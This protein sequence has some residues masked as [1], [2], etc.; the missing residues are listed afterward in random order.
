M[1]RSA[2]LN[3]VTDISSITH[4]A[5][6]SGTTPPLEQGDRLTRHEFELRYEA[7]PE[8]KKAE[9]IEGIVYMG[10]PVKYKHGR[11]HRQ[12]NHWLSAYCVETPGTD[13]A[14]NV[15]NRLDEDNDPQP[16]L[17]LRIEE[18]YGGQSRVD[19]DGYLS[20]APELIAEIASSS[21][22][23]DLHD[24]LNVYRRHGV[25]EYVV[26]R[27]R[28]KQLDWFCLEQGHYVRQTPDAKGMIASNIFPGL[29]L[30]VGALLAGEMAAVLNELHKGLA[31]AAHK[32]FVRRLAAQKR[33]LKKQSGSVT[34]KTQ[35][36][37]KR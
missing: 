31:S 32:S 33:K 27:V 23:Y 6:G 18:E 11:H 30:A 12:L 35:S 20:G 5:N 25:Q 10:S 37:K 14:D 24:K 36:R 1:K 3:E 9:L 21:A 2:E 22:A 4:S 17:L 7:M 15:T 28:D 26:W 13:V 34:K 19:E 29:R 8:L 16:D